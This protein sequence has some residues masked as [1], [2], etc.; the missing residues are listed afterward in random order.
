MLNK[1]VNIIKTIYVIK[2]LKNNRVYIGQTK[3]Y[4]KRKREHMNALK[5]N[6]HVNGYLQKDYNKYNANNFTY[7]IIEQVSDVDADVREDYWMNYFGGI[8]SMRIY[9]SMNSTT[10]SVFM[11]NK[12]SELY[13]DK[14]HVTRYGK[15]AATR[16]R[17]IN[18]QKHKGK[19]PKYIP[20]KGKVKRNDG[21][22]IV[23]SES[24]YNLIHQLRNQGLTYQQISDKT[25]IG[26]NGVRNIVLDNIHYNW[27]C[28]D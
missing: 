16:M 5:S 2:C 28:N 21:M 20:N 15:D 1:E 22:M 6:R 8:D 3:N 11:R 19:K 4:E 14:S 25:N 7:S 24:L 13:K 26:I 27:K 12:L 23:V 18:S 9:N 10:K 17:M